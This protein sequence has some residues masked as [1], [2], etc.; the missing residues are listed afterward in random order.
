M[1]TDAVLSPCSRYR[2]L[3]LREW[4]GG[5]LPLVLGINPSTADADAEDATTRKLIGFGER[6]GWGGYVLGN[7]F[8]WRST[9][10]RGLLSAPDPVGPDNMAW[11]QGAAETVP[12]IVA[13]WGSAKTAA[14]QRLLQAQLEA[15]FPLLAHCDLRC[16]GLTLGG[17][18]RHPLMLSYTTPLVRWCP[19]P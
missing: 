13:A 5:P 15:V 3:L 4:G 2:Y 18:P 12:F 7:P 8:A 19:W 6:L 9:D 17:Y 10:Q 16:W 11:L 14:V 1:R